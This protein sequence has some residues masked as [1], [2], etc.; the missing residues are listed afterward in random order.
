MDREFRRIKSGILFYCKCTYYFVKNNIINITQLVKQINKE[1][2]NPKF[3]CKF[4]YD[5]IHLNKTKKK[6]VILSFSSFLNLHS[7]SKI[8]LNQIHNIL[9]P[10]LHQ[11]T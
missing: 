6:T 9:N 5:F 8:A 1:I 4:I 7:F 2:L 10:V 11:E 3:H